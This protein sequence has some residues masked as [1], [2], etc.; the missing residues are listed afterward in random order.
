MALVS[1]VFQRDKL[2]KNNINI[3]TKYLVNGTILER[4]TDNSYNDDI[5]NGIRSLKEYYVNNKLCHTEKIFDSRIEYSFISNVLDSTEYKCSNCGVTSKLSDFIDGCPYCGTYYNIDYVNKDLGSKYH[6]DL[7]L[8]KNSYRII[9]ALI[10]LI[11]SL[12]F[13]FIFIKCT[14]RT[15]NIYDFLKIFI[16]GGL[17]SLVLYYLFYIVDGYVILLPIKKK[18]EK[19]NKLQMEFWNKTNL[20]KKSFFNNLNYEVRKMYYS[21]PDIIDYDVLDFTGYEAITKNNELYIKVKAY[22]R[23]VYFKNNK[24]ISKY[25]DDVYLLRKINNDGQIYNVADVVKCHNCGAS[26]DITRGSCQYCGSEI[27]YFQ[28]FIICENGELL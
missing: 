28:N 6:Y 5:K 14:S 15:F 22:V 26:V 1:D 17:L 19:E 12:I 18:K 25:V 7:V 21:K 16:Y 4:N 8:K 2:K 23:I 24:F 11:I 13:S 9:T 3:K 10:D 27:K 20:D